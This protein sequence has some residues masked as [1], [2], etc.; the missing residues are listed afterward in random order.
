MA[1]RIL[2]LFFLY[3]LVSYLPMFHLSAPMNVLMERLVNIIGPIILAAL[4]WIFAEPIADRITAKMTTDE[5]D[6]TI[7][8]IQL[9]IIAFSVLG[10]YFVFDS[11]SQTIS[12]F[13][14]FYVLKGGKI[15]I[16]KMI[17]QNSNILFGLGF[18]FLFGFILLVISNPLAR[19][20]QKNVRG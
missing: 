3:P 16:D 2:A 14:Y 1:C 9:H 18:K 20:L 10:I 15:T 11:L 17:L 5:T 7:S 13:T 4:L 12:T 19:F 6:K 8:A